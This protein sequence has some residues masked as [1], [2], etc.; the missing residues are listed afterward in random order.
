MVTASRQPEEIQT[1]AVSVS[2]LT[3][4]GALR[5]DPLRL[6]AA[7]VSIPGVSLVNENVNVRNSTGYTRGL[8]SRVLILLDGIPALTSDFGNMNWD[9]LPVTDFERVEVIKGPASA[10]YGSFALGGVINI[11]TKA[12]QPQGRFA[13]R[14]SAGVYD[15]PYESEWHWTDRTLI[16]IVWTRAIRGRLASSVSF[17]IGPARIHRRPGEPP[18]SALEFYR[19]INARLGRQIRA[20]ALWRLQ[21]GSPRRVRAIAPGESLSRARRIFAVSHFAR[22]LHVL[23]AI[24]LANE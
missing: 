11:I 1:A 13:I 4:A 15:Q 6:D 5:R 7:L 18:F 22:C 19:Q 17:F 9:L 23:S 12:P 8:G 21:P 16:S 20:D 3:G 10:L 14:T 24:S 2:A